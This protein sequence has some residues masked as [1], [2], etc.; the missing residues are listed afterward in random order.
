MSD[1]EL[2]K[3]F[4]EETGNIIPKSPQPMTEEEVYFIIKMILDEVME[5][6]ATISTAKDV[7]Y[8]M[9]KMI[10][11]SRDLE[12]EK[13]L[14]GSDLIASQSDAFVDIYYYIL[15]AAS[16]KGVNLS[17]IFQI[18][19]QANLNKRDPATGKFIIRYSD[20]KVLKPDGW[21]APDV[22]AEIERQIQ[23]GGF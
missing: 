13:H 3:T 18:V 4:T 23:N 2:V 16:K 12:S 14:E 6:G 10:C 17:K 11:D 21:Q 20:K 22:T 1:A 15:N 8:N 5:L 9:I 7:K 19:H